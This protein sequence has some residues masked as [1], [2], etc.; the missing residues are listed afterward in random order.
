MIA[1]KLCIAVAIGAMMLLTA[2]DVKDP[3]YE[4]TGKVTLVT[5]WTN[6]TEGIEIPASYTAVT[7][8]QTH[9]LTGTTYVLPEME[10]GTYPVLIYNTPE[11]VSVNGTAVTVATQ[12]NSVDP[13]PGWLFTYAGE[14]TAETAKETTATAVM[15]QQV[16]QL[17]IELTLTGG[18]AGDLQSITASLS[19][20]AS[21]MDYKEGSY[22]GSGLAVIPVLTRE[23]NLLKG[24]VRLIGLTT[25]AQTLT[26]SLVFSDGKEQ[27]IVSDVSGQL[28]GFNTGKH[29]PVLLTS[30]MEIAA[31]TGFEAT[32][33]PWEA[34]TESG[35]VAW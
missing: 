11:K 22:T 24:A 12:G 16:R 19:G 18:N 29:L 20:V 25:E 15:V 27:T 32:I 2:C 4:A 8:G 35:A 34:Q 33:T 5:D 14:I 26:L 3:I 17:S 30:G 7:G 10:A 23:G 1:N 31:K 9:T 13:A 6:R 21:G 28:T